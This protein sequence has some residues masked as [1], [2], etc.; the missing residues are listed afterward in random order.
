MDFKIQG[1]LSGQRTIEIIS[2]LFFHQKNKN[3][4]NKLIILVF[5]SFFHNLIINRTMKRP[6][7]KTS[8]CRTSKYRVRYNFNNKDKVKNKVNNIVK[9]K[10]IY[11]DK[12][13]EF[14]G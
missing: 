6:H 14:V 12:Y 10:I 11:K 7:W 1:S 2:L 5:I 13:K 3:C 4:N 8:N 9:D